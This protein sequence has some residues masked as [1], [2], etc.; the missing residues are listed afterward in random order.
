MRYLHSINKASKLESGN[1]GSLK[2][3][4]TVRKFLM[5]TEI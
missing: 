1:I 5:E 2:Q 4:S 3:G